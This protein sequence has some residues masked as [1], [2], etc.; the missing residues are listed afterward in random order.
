M[1]Y[2][3]KSP[4]LWAAIE[5]EE[6]RQQDTIELI[7]SENI[8]SDAVREAQGSVLTNKYAEGY[9]NKRY[10]GGCEF[11]DQVEQLAIDYAKKLFNAAY[12]NVQ[13]HSGSQANMA[14]YQA[15]LKPG[16]V[17]LGMGMDAGGH[18]T[19]GATVN[20]SG[21]L[22]KTYGYGLNPDTEE[23]DYDEIMALAKKVKPQLIVAGASAYSRIIDWQAFRKIADEVGAYLMVD[24]AHIAGLVATGAHPSPLPI[25]DVVT[26]TTHK[27]LRG[28][29]GGMI[30]SKST[31]LGRKINSAVFPGI[32]GGPLEHVIAGKAQALYEDLQPEYAEYIQQIVKNAQAMEKVFNTSKQIRV[33]SGKTEN[34]LLVLDLTKTGLTGKDAQNLLDRVHIT[35]N[36]EAIPNDPRSPFITSGLRIGTPA[37]TSRGFKEEDAQ[38]VAELISTALTNP[39]DEERL[40]EVAK[41]VHELTTKYPIN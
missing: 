34:H 37:I 25:A 5:N 19:H 41:D 35:T 6:Q 11:I 36:K 38:R 1:N 8:V 13:P 28:P 30:L 15:L 20:F 39:T 32:Q 7:A 4:Q 26:T 33:V 31:E 14:V 24:M 16:D 2:G 22:Y 23:L 27:T 3:K 17:I 12:A 9:P 29:R 18:L 40:Q 10:Y 21:K